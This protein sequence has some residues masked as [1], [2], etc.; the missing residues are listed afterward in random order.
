[1]LSQLSNEIESRPAGDERLV[2][3][4]IIVVISSTSIIIHIDE[5]FKLIC[6]I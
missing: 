4:V 2:V 3:Y 5:P 1:M 6:T